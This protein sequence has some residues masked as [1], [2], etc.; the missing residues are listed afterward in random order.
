MK[1]THNFSL[2]TIFLVIFTRAVAL[3]KIM[4]KMVS[5]ETLFVNLIQNRVIIDTNLMTHTHTHTHTHHTT[6]K[7]SIYYKPIK[8]KLNI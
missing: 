4:R 1:W 8:V 6:T 3:V 5:R 2:I 7:L